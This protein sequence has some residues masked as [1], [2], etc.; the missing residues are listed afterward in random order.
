MCQLKDATITLIDK[1]SNLIMESV[2]L[3]RNVND[4]DLVLYVS[5]CCVLSK[6]SVWES[7]SDE[8]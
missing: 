8:L 4:G 6:R 1:W 5:V 3:S 7:G 2:V